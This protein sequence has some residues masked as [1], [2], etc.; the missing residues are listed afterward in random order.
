MSLQQLQQNLPLVR[1]W[2]NHTLA[3]H[4][5][6]ARSVASLGFTRLGSYYSTGLLTSATAI[7]V[8]SV[9][10]PP[11]ASMKLTGLDEFEN[12]NAAGITYLSSFFVR[13]GYE[14]DESLHFHEL[15]H[16]VQW[17]HLGP[18]RFI[19]AYALGHLLTGGYRT[20]PLEE[21]AYTLQ[22][23]FDRNEPAFDVAA[24]VRAELDRV[25]RILLQRAS[26]GEL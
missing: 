7:P 18:E 11:L 25:V 16:V 20:N 12:L 3:A 9:P 23:R 19:M 17:Q 21:M 8:V 13:L 24:V 10:V 1:A 15:V 2:I 22:A 26:A 14:H 5:T 4:A 6:Q